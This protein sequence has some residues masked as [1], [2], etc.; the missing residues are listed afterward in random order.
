MTCGTIPATMPDQT[1]LQKR[2]RERMDELG[3]NAARAALDAGLK[4]DAIRDILRGR[5]QSPR[6]VNAAAIARALQWTVE[7]LLEGPVQSNGRSHTG[8]SI[9]TTRGEVEVRGEIYAG[10]W[11]PSPDWPKAQRYAATLPRSR[12]YPRAEGMVAYEVSDRSCDRLCDEGGLIFAAPLEG[13]SLKWGDHVVIETTRAGLT[14]R[15]V[16]S[17]S[18]TPDGDLVLTTPTSAR[19]L[20]ETAVIPRGDGASGLHDRARRYGPDSAAAAID[21]RP[22]PDD[23]TVITGLVMGWLTAK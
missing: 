11:N 21:Y 10:D 13:A 3:T 2:I 18:V 4:K 1:D 9:A 20:Q 19:A 15:R 12:K 8:L 22:E 5:T 7:D 6:A 23:E 14:E 17:V 16:A